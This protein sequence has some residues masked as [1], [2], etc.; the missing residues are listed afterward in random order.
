MG[1]FYFQENNNGVI[2]FLIALLHLQYLV[3]GKLN[4]IAIYLNAAQR[5]N[6]KFEHKNY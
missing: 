4:D 5:N 6:K 2:K 3:V 1:I